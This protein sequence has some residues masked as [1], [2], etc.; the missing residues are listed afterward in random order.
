MPDVLI[1]IFGIVFSFG[2]TG[3]IAYVI[4][5]ILRTRMRVRA[6]TELQSKLI[7]RLGAQDIGAFLNSESGTQMLRALAEHPGGDAAP[8]RILRALQSGLVLLAVGLGLSAYG[9]IRPLSIE[10]AD[11]VIFFA[12]LATALG[13]GLLA[14]AGASYTLSRRLGLLERGEAR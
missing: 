3:Y 8:I 2:L 9:S 5:E 4:L 6:T 1:P 7:D 13:I 10:A 11:S 12:V 14:A